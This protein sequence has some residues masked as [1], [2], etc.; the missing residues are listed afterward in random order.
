MSKN[1]KMK[2][3]GMMYSIFFGRRNT[4]IN[5]PTTSSRTISGGSLF[6]NIFSASP[7]TYIPREKRRRIIMEKVRGVRSAIQ[8]IRKPIRLPAVPGA[9]GK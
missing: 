5:A 8:K 3:A 1:L 9:T 4:E 2:K 6:S 7:D